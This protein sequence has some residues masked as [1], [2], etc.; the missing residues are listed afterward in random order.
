MAFNEQELRE[1]EAEIN[2]DM[3][4]PVWRDYKPAPVENVPNDLTGIDDA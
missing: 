4:L 2:S 1:I 3:L